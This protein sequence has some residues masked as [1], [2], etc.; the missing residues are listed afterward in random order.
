[1]APGVYNYVCTR[2]NNFSN[3]SQKGQIVVTPA[4]SDALTAGQKAGVAIGTIA[5]AGLLLG[6]VL[7]Y[8]KRH[9]NTRAGAAVASLSACQCKPG[10]TASSAPEMKYTRGT[11]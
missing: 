3:R 8:G 10:T 5:G 4:S 2:N 7:F 9:P 1:M 11:A 6:G